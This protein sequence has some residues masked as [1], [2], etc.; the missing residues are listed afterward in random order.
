[1]IDEEVRPPGP[2]DLYLNPQW[3]QVQI[4]HLFQYLGQEL[5]TGPS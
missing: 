4:S 5:L 3:H 1:M 2:L